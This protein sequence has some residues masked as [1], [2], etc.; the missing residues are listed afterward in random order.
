MTRKM[1]R[2]DFLRGAA[3]VSAAAIVD[4]GASIRWFGEFSKPASL[5]GK[6]AWL[7]VSEF[8]EYLNRQLG[9]IPD[10][11][12]DDEIPTEFFTSGYTQDQLELDLQN[13]AL[14]N[15]FPWGL[16]DT[17]TLGGIPDTR[18]VT[19]DEDGSAILTIRRPTPE[20]LSAWQANPEK[21]ALIQEGEKN[22][23]EMKLSVA[24]LTGRLP[25][26][27]HSIEASITPPQGIQ[28]GDLKTGMVGTGWSFWTLPDDERLLQEL[29]KR[30]V[31][32]K[33]TQEILL[34]VNTLEEDIGE[35]SLGRPS[36]ALGYP[37]WVSFLGGQVMTFMAGRKTFTK[38]CPRAD[39]M[40][41]LYEPFDLPARPLMPLL[42]DRTLSG[43]LKAQGRDSAE[44][45][46][47]PLRVKM[48][49][50]EEIYDPTREAMVAPMTF[51]LYGKPLT[52]TA[53]RG[54]AGFET[55]RTGSTAANLSVTRIRTVGGDWIS[56]P[57]TFI[58]DFCSSMI[59]KV[60]GETDHVRFSNIVIT[61]REDAPS[62]GP[63]L[64]LGDLRER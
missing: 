57:R 17:H 26:E 16:A 61:R 50:G 37:M 59:H 22:G 64:D 14:R 54:F 5:P 33:E 20:Q 3:F 8:S 48:E 30:K 43:W 45:L 56:I 13:G 11:G 2:R 25:T 32:A 10:P 1:T 60:E 12:S 19:I 58:V 4:P 46:K 18:N 27:L 62:G 42:A 53:T 24:A 29:V 40:H 31:P 44:W 51:S 28:A 6:A 52:P 63:Y 49:I 9:Q 38:L 21:K 34:R 39:I 55:D 36:T 47:E 23:V 41:M 15:G 35:F 7:L